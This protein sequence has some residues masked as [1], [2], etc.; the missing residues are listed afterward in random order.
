MGRKKIERS[1]K[2]PF[3][4]WANS[5]IIDRELGEKLLAMAEA[6]QRSVNNWIQVMISNEWKRRAQNLGTGEIVSTATVRVQA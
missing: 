2:E 1:E 3:V 4:L 6:D 5:K